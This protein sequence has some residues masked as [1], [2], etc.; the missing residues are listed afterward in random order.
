MPSL[1][2]TSMVESLW[3]EMYETPQDMATE[4]VREEQ[5]RIIIELGSSY[6]GNVTPSNASSKAISQ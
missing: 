3:R 2:C 1:D 5:V 4:T 6:F